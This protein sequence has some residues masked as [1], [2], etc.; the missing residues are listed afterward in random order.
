M[1]RFHGEIGFGEMQD[2]GMGIN[3]D[4]IVRAKQYKGDVLKALRHTQ[5]GNDQLNDDITMTNRISIVA[6]QYANNNFL[7]IRYVV[8]MG[9][10]WKVTSVESLPPRLIVTL[11]GVYNG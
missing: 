7:S 3:Q 6:D 4:N 8:Y 11:G 10:K 5:N 1:A 9:V 2:I